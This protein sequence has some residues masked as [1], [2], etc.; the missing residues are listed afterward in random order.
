M[1]PEGAPVG[2]EVIVVEDVLE[3]PSCCW[4][5]MWISGNACALR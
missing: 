3:W 1:T 2:G 4:T 5:G